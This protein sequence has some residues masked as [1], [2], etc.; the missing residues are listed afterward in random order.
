MGL[1]SFFGGASSEPT[2]VDPNADAKIPLPT[3]AVLMAAA[4]P[5]GEKCWETNKLFYECKK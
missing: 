5:I 3:Q 1:F 2:S 4:L